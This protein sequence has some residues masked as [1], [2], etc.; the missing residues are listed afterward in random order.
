MSVQCCM[1][2]LQH[3]A[4]PPQPHGALVVPLVPFVLFVP[5]V[6]PRPPTNALS[7]SNHPR[8]RPN[9]GIQAQGNDE[10]A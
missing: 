2:A 9:G 5:Y 7:Q 4:A 6:P 10:P 3:N 8:V 1:C